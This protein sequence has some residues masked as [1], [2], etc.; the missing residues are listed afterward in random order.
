MCDVSMKVVQGPVEVSN[1]RQQEPA[2]VRLLQKKNK[3]LAAANAASFIACLVFNALAGSGKLTGT[4]IGQVSALFPTFITPAGFAFSIWGVI[5]TCMALL[6]LFSFTAQGQRSERLFH[7]GATA[8]GGGIG[9][10]FA[11]SNTTNII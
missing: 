8:R 11:A 9:W 1:L 10:T 3:R 6:V 5:Y 2:A 4:S 7:Q